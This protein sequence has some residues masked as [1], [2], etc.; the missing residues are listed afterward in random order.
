MKRFNDYITHVSGLA[1]SKKGI[2]TSVIVPE[3]AVSSCDWNF[4]EPERLNLAHCGY[5]TPLRFL[6][7]TKLSKRATKAKLAILFSLF[8]TKKFDI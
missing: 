2:G 5:K 8:S 6:R 7:A 4:L 1:T 3:R